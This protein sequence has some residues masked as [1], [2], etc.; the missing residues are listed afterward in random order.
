MGIKGLAER[1]RSAMSCDICA[2]ECV[3]GEVR[4]RSVA[5]RKIEK[6]LAVSLFIDIVVYC[7]LFIE[8]RLLKPQ[9]IKIA[10]HLSFFFYDVH[11][12]NDTS[13]MNASELLANTLSPGSPSFTFQAPVTPHPA[14]HRHR[15]A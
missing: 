3:R 5:T 7:P 10:T 11:A 14:F 2:G 13:I 9:L 1:T 8:L 12:A 6:P 15:N 4:I